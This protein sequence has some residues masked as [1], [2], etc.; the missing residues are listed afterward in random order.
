[1]LEPFPTAVVDHLPMPGGIPLSLRN[2]AQGCFTPS[3]SSLQVPRKKGS[4]PAGG[5]GSLWISGAP[6]PGPAGV[7]TSVPFSLCWSF[8]GPPPHFWV[9]QMD[10]P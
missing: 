2:P 3:R 5:G 4:P 7:L 6:P 8:C 9:P 1:M 10:S